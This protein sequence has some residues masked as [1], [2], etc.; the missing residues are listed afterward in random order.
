MLNM[1]TL[2]HMNF[3]R[4]FLKLCQKVNRE[5]HQQSIGQS[6][7]VSITEYPEVNTSAGILPLALVREGG[8]PEAA[9][10]RPGSSALRPNG[11]GGWGMRHTLLFIPNL[12]MV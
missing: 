8:R 1:S 4:N 3:G 12:G 6:F 10:A 7:W 11:Q 9:R 5:V 2:K